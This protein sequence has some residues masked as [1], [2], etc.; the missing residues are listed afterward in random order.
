MDSLAR[1]VAAVRSGEVSPVELVEAALEAAEEV[2]P[3]L[4]AFTV[5]LAEEARAQAKALEGT[6][7]VGPLHGIPVV[8]KDLF[9]LT[10]APTTGC[11]AAYAGR[12]ATA[13]SA[14]VEALRAAG[15]VV[16]AK[17]NQHELGAG[18]TGLVSCIGPAR[19]PCDP[20]RL[21]G[22]SSSGSAV[23]VAAGVTALGIGSDTGGS[24]RMPAS[25]CG[26][27]GLKTTHGRVSLRGAMPMSP[28][29]DSAGP[30][31]RSAADCALAFRI[32]AG[33]EPAAGAFAPPPTG[34]VEPT[35][36][37]RVGLPRAFFRLVHPETRAAVEGAARA[38][39]DLGAAV[40]EIDGPQLDEGWDGFKF[41]W[42][43]VAHGHP[44]LW[45]DPGVHAEVASLIDFGRAM[46]GV[47]YA[48]SRSRAREI[49]ASFEQ[50]LT[51]VDVLLAPA[52]PYPA[53][54]VEAQEVAVE[55][56]ALDVH[57][58]SPSRLTVPVNLAGLPSLAFP[59]GMSS[60]GLPL[61][62]QLIGRPWAEETLLA[63]ID[64]YQQTRTSHSV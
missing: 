42:A 62:A 28:A 14:V 47:D 51:V 17:T 30:L 27:T 38:L 44:H 41:V 13:D 25:F 31:A 1:Q 26:V 15:A 23:A 9:D 53:P 58:G 8:V 52:T 5:V 10:G 45:D 6:G 33:H 56:G 40:E 64:A 35:P 3:R 57:S 32:L 29:L 39:E 48:A 34:P 16:V 2:Q 61:G 46:S 37:L 4:N 63:W 12:L 24:I 21:P 55:G 54:P 59:V 49:R 36:G 7:P 11:C 18:A 22:G 20:G 19:N 60:E 50:S 43:D